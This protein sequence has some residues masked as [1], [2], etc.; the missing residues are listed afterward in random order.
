VTELPPVER[1][2]ERLYRRFAPAVVGYLRAQGVDDPEAVMQE[3]F[4]SVLARIDK[5]SGGEDGAR[6][7][8][9]TIAHAR[10]VDHHRQRARVTPTIEYSPEL[11]G[12]STRSAEEIAL[13]QAGDES[14]IAI[15]SSLKEDHRE[16]LLLRVVADLPLEHVAKVMGKSVGSI[17]QLQR[18]A[19][20]A[21]SK[22]PDIAKG[23]LQ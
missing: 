4:I 9:F 2:F 12:R 20:L 10:V 1:S 21:L 13:A 8:L 15:L 11:D 3:V 18:R 7:L 19:L 6:T 22:H 5:I 23:A 17:K 14:T 16:V